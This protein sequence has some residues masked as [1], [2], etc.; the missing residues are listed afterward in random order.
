[1]YP[2]I[3]LFDRTVGIY[4]LCMAL[5]FLLVV[6]LSV[7]RGKRDEITFDDIIL[8]AA[9]AIGMGLLG[10][11]LTYILVTYT[12]AEVI[13]LIRAG[14]WET[15]FTGLV[16]YGS[17]AG[18]FLGAILGARLCGRSLNHFE[19]SVVPLLPLGHAIGRVGCFLGGCC[20]GMEYTG[21]GAVYYP[22][23][24]KIGHFPVQLLEAFCNC[25]LCLF[26]LWRGNK[27]FGRYRLALTYLFTYAV[28]RFMLEFLRGDAIRGIAL[29]LSISQWLSLGILIFC[30]CFLINQKNAKP[31]KADSK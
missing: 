17:L 24:P 1:M 3:S 29:G 14:Q 9:C 4:G 18:G 21:F 8:F 26:L 27:P 5:A 10:G 25:L 2:T 12:A 20:Y 28:E 13:S 11:N 7:V 15:V 16:F 22:F 6:T 30:I 19:R 31:V 23:E